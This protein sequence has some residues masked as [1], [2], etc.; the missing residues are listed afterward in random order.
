[1]K[2]YDLTD[3]DVAVIIG[4]GPGGATLALRL[5]QQGL[6]VVLLEAGPW[7]TND[8]FINDERKSYKQLTWTDTR[9]ATGS[10]SLAKD[11]P[12]SPAWNGKAVGGTATFWTGL[13][14]RFKWHEFKTH[15]YYGDL[16]D[17]T[18]A[19]WPLD[20]DELDHYYTEAEKAVGASHR[21]G[22]PPLPASNGYKVLAN[23]A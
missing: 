17:G 22:R 6:K 15:T 3:D 10:W 4:S 7:I 2:K 1:M 11:F 20:L 23:G 9:L 21:H 8:K 12:G 14:P 16:P 5:V 18:I 19:D 13:T